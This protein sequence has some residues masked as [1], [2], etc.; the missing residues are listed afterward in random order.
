MPP[1][2]RSKIEIRN[3][4][5]MT[6]PIADAARKNLSSNTSLTMRRME[7]PLSVAC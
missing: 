3:N 4:E 2:T 6:E 5:V 1:I 7:K